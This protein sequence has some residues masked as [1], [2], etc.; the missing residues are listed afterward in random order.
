MQT[1][2]KHAIADIAPPRNA[3][4][5]IRSGTSRLWCRL[6]TVIKVILT[7]PLVMA[8]LGAEIELR[9]APQF[10]VILTAA[11]VWAMWAWLIGGPLAAM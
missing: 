10:D 1:E 7:V 2:K 11:G 4:A 9:L 5:P 3:S 8:L 6:P